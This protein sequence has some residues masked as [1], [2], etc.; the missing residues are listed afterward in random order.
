MARKFE[1]VGVFELQ[2]ADRKSVLK[3]SLIAMKNSLVSSY[4]MNDLYPE[5]FFYDLTSS[6]TLDLSDMIHLVI[7]AN[8]HKLSSGDIYYNG[9]VGVSADFSP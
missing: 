8:I 6:V 2:V 9:R 4:R 5:G 3:D 1:F 7:N